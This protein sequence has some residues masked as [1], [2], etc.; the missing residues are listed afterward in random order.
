VEQ[1]EALL[2]SRPDDHRPRSRREPQLP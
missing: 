1:V 2:R